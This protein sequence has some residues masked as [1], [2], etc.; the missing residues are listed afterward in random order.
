MSLFDL[1]VVVDHPPQFDGGE[2]RREFQPG[3]DPGP[4]R[5]DIAGSEILHITQGL[6]TFL[7]LLKLAWRDFKPNTCKRMFVMGHRIFRSRV[8]P[9]DSPAQRLSSLA[10]PRHGRFTLVRDA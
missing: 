3:S 9:H 2:I 8:C 5:R 6:D 10:M 1:W 4:S 7:S